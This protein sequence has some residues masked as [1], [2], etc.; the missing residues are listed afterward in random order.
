M[1]SA[2]STVPVSLRLPEDL[3]L[4]L[5]RMARKEAVLRDADVTLSDIV[6]E[7]LAE[8]YGA[9]EEPRQEEVLTQ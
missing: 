5:K 6:R 4:T 7:G 2:E 1:A 8:V 3:Y 9:A